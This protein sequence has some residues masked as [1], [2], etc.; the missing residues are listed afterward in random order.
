[1]CGSTG[2]AVVGK[3]FFTPKSPFFT[4]YFEAG[5]SGVVGVA[6]VK[7]GKSYTSYRNQEPVVPPVVGATVP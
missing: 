6:A 1:M 2:T 7:A 3:A 5:I 4:Q